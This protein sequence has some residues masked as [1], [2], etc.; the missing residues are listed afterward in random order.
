MVISGFLSDPGV[1]FS[2]ADAN[3]FA[4]YNGAGSVRLNIPARCLAEHYVTVGF[5]NLAASLGQTLFMTVNDT[6]QAGAQIAIRG[7]SYTTIPE[8]SALALAWLVAAPLVWR[9]KR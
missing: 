3:L 1:T 9:R 5:P 4:V 7:I 8:P 2:T 6:T